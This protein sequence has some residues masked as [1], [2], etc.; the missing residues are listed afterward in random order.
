MSNLISGNEVN[1]LSTCSRWAGNLIGPECPL[2][3]T[4]FGG[5]PRRA[6]SSD[7][8]PASAPNLISGNAG[9]GVQSREATITD[10]LIGTDVTGRAALPNGENGEIDVQ[11]GA[12]VRITDNVTP[13]HGLE[14]GP[15]PEGDRSRCRDPC[16]RTSSAPMRRVCSPS[17]MGR[18]GAGGVVRIGAAVKPGRPCQPG[19]DRTLPGGSDATTTRCDAPCNVVSGNGG[20]GLLW[21]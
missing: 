7:W 19:L 18:V 3:V 20:L 1:I 8:A 13:G 4:R 9:N 17:R 2:G 14:P 6:S 11:V 5:A 10:N 16:S 15:P 12:E 21:R